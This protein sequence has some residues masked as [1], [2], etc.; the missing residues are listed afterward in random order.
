MCKNSL[1]L[2]NPLKIAYIR[3]ILYEYKE[4]KFR[5]NKELKMN[6]SI[7]YRNKKVEYEDTGYF[8][9]RQS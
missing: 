1:I 9:K 5:K 4:C 3:I 8:N 7:F 6:I 2:F